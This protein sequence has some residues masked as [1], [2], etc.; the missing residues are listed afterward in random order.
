MSY[1]CQL[2]KFETILSTECNEDHFEIQVH[3]PLNC[4]NE[5][6]IFCLLSRK[7]Y[8]NIY[9]LQYVGPTIRTTR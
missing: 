5:F 9:E 2:L 1:S 4:S 7:Y 8:Y 6:I 3:D